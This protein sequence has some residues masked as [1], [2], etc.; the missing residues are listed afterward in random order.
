M[1][2]DTTK[3]EGEHRMKVNK[4]CILLT[5]LIDFEETVSYY[6]EQQ[7]RPT[8]L[9]LGFHYHEITTLS[10]SHMVLNVPSHWA[11][12]TPRILRM[13]LT[14]WWCVC[15]PAPVQLCTASI[16]TGGSSGNAMVPGHHLPWPS[17]PWSCHDITTVRSPIWS[18]N[19]HHTTQHKNHGK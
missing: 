16:T 1:I 17:W 4:D 12:Q 6:F 13:S 19:L 7:H 18:H 5:K 11:W 2:Q 3:K 14:T 10:F 9:V 8:S 15:V